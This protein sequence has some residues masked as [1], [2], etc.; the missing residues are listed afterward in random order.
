LEEDDMHAK[1]T[2]T[3]MLAGAL[4]AGACSSSQTP[5]PMSGTPSDLAQLAGEWTG[6]YSSRETGRSG[7]IVFKLVGGT[8]SAYGDVLMSPTGM[9]V[10]AQVPQAGAP[11]SAGA[12]QQ[13][14]SQAITISFARIAGGRVSGRLAPYTDPDCQCPLLTVFEGRLSGDVLEGTYTSRRQ[15]GGAEQHGQWRVTRRTP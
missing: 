13:P 10:Q 1:L 8:D 5:V 14:S 4:A 3:L 11:S 15:S 2:V 6:Q 7:S 12:A 9:H